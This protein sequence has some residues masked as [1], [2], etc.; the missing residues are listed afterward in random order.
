MLGVLVGWILAKLL[1]KPMLSSS[2]FCVLVGLTLPFLLNHGS[3]AAMAEAAGPMACITFGLF[4]VHTCPDIFPATAKI[5][6]AVWLVLEPAVFVL[7]GCELDFGKL[8]TLKFVQLMGLFILSHGMRT[9]GAVF[10]II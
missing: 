3:R 8:S 7:I 5:L 2:T 1:V 10:H 4:S 6:D 9:L